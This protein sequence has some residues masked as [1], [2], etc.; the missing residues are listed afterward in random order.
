[1]KNNKRDSGFMTYDNEKI[2]EGDIYYKVHEETFILSPE[3]E[4]LK[5][6]KILSHKWKVFANKKNAQIFIIENK[7]CLSLKEIRDIIKESTSFFFKQGKVNINFE[8][9]TQL[10]KL[11]LN[12]SI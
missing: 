6:V 7:P 8:K 10:V 11:K 4:V 12:I 9:L 3:L 1:M 2:Y 5:N